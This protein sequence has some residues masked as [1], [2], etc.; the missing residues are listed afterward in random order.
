MRTISSCTLLAALCLASLPAVCAAQGFDGRQ[1]IL[2]FVDK[3]C[4][5]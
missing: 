3:A 2:S 5:R 1:R 4:A